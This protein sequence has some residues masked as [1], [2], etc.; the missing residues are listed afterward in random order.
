MNLPILGASESA[1]F[2]WYVAPFRKLRQSGAGFLECC[3]H[4]LSVRVTVI[5]SYVAV[6]VFDVPLGLLG[7]LDGER[8]QARLSFLTIANSCK[9]LANR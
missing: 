9:G 6:D 7:N 2:F 3:K 8:H 4:P 5:L 1:Q